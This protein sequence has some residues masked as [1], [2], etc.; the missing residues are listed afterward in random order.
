MLNF[1]KKGTAL[2]LAA[3]MLLSVL[4]G[5]N[6]GGNGEV[7]DS[8]SG[9]ESQT[10]NKTDGPTVEDDIVSWLSR[11]YTKNMKN[12]KAPE[13]LST[14]ADVH[15]AKNETE[16][17]QFSFT[18][19]RRKNGYTLKTS[20]SYEGIELEMFRLHFVSANNKYYPDPIA[21]SEGVVS[22]SAGETRSLLVNFRTSASTKAGTYV[23]DFELCNK[24]GD[25]VQTYKVTVKV[26]NITY[27]ETPTLDTAFG[28]EYRSVAYSHGIIDSLPNPYV[29]TQEELEAGEEIYLKYYEYMLDHKISPMQLPYDIL[30]PRADKYM[31][32]PRWTTFNVPSNVSDATLKAYYDKLCSNPVW[33]EKAYIY[34]VDEPTNKAHLDTM[35]EQYER[36]QRICPDIK[37]ATSFFVNVNYDSQRDQLQVMGEILDILCSKISNWD[38]KKLGWGFGIAAHPTLGSFADRMH[39]YKAEGKEIWSYVCWEPQAP[40]LNLL[41]TD[42]GLDH[43]LV[44]WQQYSLGTTGFLY[45]SVNCYGHCRDPWKGVGSWL[46]DDIHGDGILLYP[47]SKIDID[48]PVGSLRFEA[49]RDGVEDNEILAMAEELLGKAYVTEQI[50]RIVTDITKYTES[51]ALFEEVRA[52]LLSD[53]EK[54]LSEK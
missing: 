49:C 41:L 29:P 38:E 34:P 9:S 8:E 13:T 53:V 47:G 5:C 16:G 18:A 33:L 2:A 52:K 4:A 24:D 20:D 46:G 54:A 6:N 35:L 31:S 43:R 44:F 14:A 37:M 39:K 30:D 11:G 25:T 12:G 26:Y 42:E 27:P 45:W 51:D 40:Y 22:F 1:I 3:L 50:G 28:I 15:M 23:Y 32:D 17:I 10:E 19:N 7:T 48:G 36:Y 21:P